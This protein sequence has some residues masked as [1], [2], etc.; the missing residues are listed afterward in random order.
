MPAD[1]DFPPLHCQI[2]PAF[3]HRQLRAAGAFLQG[4]GLAAVLALLIGITA[5]NAPSRIRPLV[6]PWEEETDLSSPLHAAPADRSRHGSGDDETVGA[7]PPGMLGAV[8]IERRIIIRLPTLRPVPGGP[9][10]PPVKLA[11]KP[12]KQQTTCLSLKTL[13]GASV[14]DQTGILFITTSDSR[15][16]AMLERGCRPVD[17]QSGFYVGSTTDGAVC[18]GRDILYARSGMQCAISSFVRIVP[19]H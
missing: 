12:A 9:P 1:M 11:G 10:A 2:N 18:A 5:G 15:Y 16:Q 17:F 4:Q 13:K 19:E 6:V 3:N 8:R 14:S 7:L